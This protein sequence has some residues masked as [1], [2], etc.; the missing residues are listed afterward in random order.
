MA[1]KA[2]KAKRSTAKKKSSKPEMKLAKSDEQK[3]ARLPSVGVVKSLANVMISGQSKIDDISGSNS[4]AMRE[5]VERRGVH[6]RAFRVAL[7]FYKRAKKD[8]A[9]FAVEIQH[10]DHYLECFGI[11]DLI[12][13]EPTLPMD[14]DSQAKAAAAP[15][16]KAASKAQRSDGK[17]DPV[18]AQSFADPEADKHI[19]EQSR[20]L[21]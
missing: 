9:S 19:E 11:D 21:N 10:F 3:A 8:P 17:Q 2:K 7:G 6:Q 13:E 12:A 16:V 14:V 4:S 15:A 5:A 20:H 18:S 1:K